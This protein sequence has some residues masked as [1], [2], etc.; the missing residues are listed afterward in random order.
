MIR[1]IIHN[2][3]ISPPFFVDVILLT[4]FFTIDYHKH[5]C[6]KKNTCMGIPII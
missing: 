6:K 5:N 2:N 3:F 1:F 4:W